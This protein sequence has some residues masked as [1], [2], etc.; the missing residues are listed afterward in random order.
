EMKRL[1]FRGEDRLLGA[2]IDWRV[3]Q[4]SDLQNHRSQAGTPRDHVCTAN[5]AKLPRYGISFIGPR[6]GLRRTFRVREHLCGQEHE[7]IRCSTR[8]V[9]TRPAVA[10]RSQ[11]WLTLRNIANRTAINPAFEPHGTSPASP[12]NLRSGNPSI[13]CW[14]CRGQ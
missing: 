8:H 12:T 11:A 9:L 14:H 2:A 1:T 4:R 5:R 3:I 7:T 6:V 13:A 10:L